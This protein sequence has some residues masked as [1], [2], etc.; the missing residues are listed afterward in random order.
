MYCD[1]I[2]NVIAEYLKNP[3]AEYAVLIDGDWGSGKTYF[4]THSLMKIIKTIDDGKGQ[5]RKYAYISLYGAKS[6]D[7][8]SKEI[9]FQCLG[10][11]HKKKFETADTI[12]ETAS[13]ILTASLGA[14]NI[15]LSKIKD[16]LAKIDIN[17]W[18]IC[19]DDLERCCLHINEILGYMNHLVEHNNCK[20]IVLANEKEIGKITLNQRLEEKYQVI[21]AGRKLILENADNS[22]TSN[23]KDTIDIKELKDKIELV[24]DEDILYES[25]REKV[26]GLTIKFDPQMNVAFDSI[27]SNFSSNKDFKNYLVENKP[28]ILKYFE[29]EEC[30]NLRT[31]ISVLESMQKVY[32]EMVSHAFN[33]VKYFDKIMEEFSKYIILLTIYYR[34][35]GKVRELNLTTEIGYVPLGQSI[36]DQARGFKFLEKYCTSLSF[37]EQEFIRVVSLLRQEYDQE[38]KWIAKSKQ[39]L[40]RSYGELTY[41]WKKEDDEVSDL[42]EQLW[43]EIKQD[44][45]PFNNYQGI[46]GQLMVLQHYGHDIGNMD[47][48]IEIMNQN[49]ENSEEIVD[50]EMHSYSF[51]NNPEIR[52]QYDEYVSRLNLKAMNKNR[53]I[54]A[55]ELLQFMD[56]E[57][58]AE[59]LFNYCENHFNEFLSRYGFI[60][61]VDINVLLKKMSTA[62]TKDMYL[63]E[64]ALKI[65]YKASN[66]NE[67]FVN[68]SGEIKKFREAVEQM[69][70]SGINKALAK[71]SLEDCLDN[72]IK[73]L[74]K[75][76]NA[77]E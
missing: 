40:A 36:F 24:F 2:E 52:E 69:S 3:R 43:N 26:I 25:I 28:K 13:N 44:K 31:L 67:F 51:K 18:I 60:D 6:I 30:Y 47:E 50:I 10:K 66:I 27:I 17:S 14:V 9:V 41:W 23:T 12:I 54:K 20:V 22:E 29:E 16:T 45:Y 53:I 4:L 37:S 68:D 15:D 70:V 71:K 62:S 33:T 56:S 38:E 73:R 57:T 39:G 49:I 46:I 55:G 77:T 64:D 11:K 61:L 35:G 63:V 48:M 42:I 21:L 65:V 74:E 8:V 32:N 1:E 75:D 5:R 76:V 59:E 7:E 58:W 72:I 34:N 19:F